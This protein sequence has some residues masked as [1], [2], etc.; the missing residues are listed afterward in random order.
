V[1][2]ICL[3]TAYFFMAEGRFNCAQHK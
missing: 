1:S 3:L 2:W